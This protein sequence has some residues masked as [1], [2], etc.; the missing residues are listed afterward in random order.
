MEELRKKLFSEYQAVVFASKVIPDPPEREQYGYAYIPFKEGATPIRQKPFMMH[1]ERHEA[2]KRVVQDWIDNKYIERPTK[3]R[4]EWLS[5]GFV[6]PKKGAD[7]PW[8]GVADM[9]G[10]NSQTRRSNYPLPHIE[11][12]L[13]KHGACHTF[14]DC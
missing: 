13:I 10:P 9:R 12:I 1:G 14:F 2:Y 4:G 6:V 7:F 8:R 11:D 5:Q 3:G